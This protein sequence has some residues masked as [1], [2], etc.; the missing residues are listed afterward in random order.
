[1]RRLVTSPEHLITLCV[2]WTGR[3]GHGSPLVGLVTSLLNATHL[4]SHGSPPRRHHRPRTNDGY[5]SHPHRSAEP[6]AWKS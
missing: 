4:L 1:M 6:E 5:V 3:F 2:L